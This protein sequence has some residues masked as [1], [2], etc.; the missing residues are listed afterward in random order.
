MAL[1]PPTKGKLLWGLLVL[2]LT[3]SPSSQV[4]NLSQNV[5]RSTGSNRVGISPCLTPSMIPYI[6]NRGGPMVGLEA[7]HLQGL[8][9]D[10]L[11]LTRET[12][13]QL[14]D[15]AGNAMS[16]TVFGTSVLVAL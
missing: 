12:E 7:L 5:D 4:W 15:L 8:P 3:C 11:L 14:S 2:P 9:I 10:E 6:T 16:T 13:D 1:I